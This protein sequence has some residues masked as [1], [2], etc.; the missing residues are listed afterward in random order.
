MSGLDERAVGM[1]QFE[2]GWWKYAGAKDA[3]I[4]DTFDLSPTRYYQLLNAVIDDPAA[5]EVDG[6]VVLR[7]RRL[8]DQR[9]QARASR[10]LAG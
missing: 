1:L 2:R 10:R 8:R 3:A 6:P 7:L 9:Q 4:R 5:L